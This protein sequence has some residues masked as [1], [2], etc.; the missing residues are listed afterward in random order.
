MIAAAV[1]GL[2]GIVLAF[3]TIMIHMVNLRSFGLPYSTPFAPTFFKDITNTAIRT[4]VSHLEMEPE[5]LKSGDHQQ[6]HNRKR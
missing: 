6:N 1:F 3:I 2:Y 5:M 4:P